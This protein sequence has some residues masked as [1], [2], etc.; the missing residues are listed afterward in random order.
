MIPVGGRHREGESWSL[1]LCQ[2]L[3]EKSATRS[4][5]YLQ[6]FLAGHIKAREMFRDATGEVFDAMSCVKLLEHSGGHGG[7]ELCQHQSRR[8]A[9]P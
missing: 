8:V 7:S 1:R 5:C 2:G 6:K 4:C 9:L 3:Q